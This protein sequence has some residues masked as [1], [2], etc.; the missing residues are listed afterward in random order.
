MKKTALLALLL[1]LTLVTASASALTLTGY[2][3]ESV[4]RYWEESRFFPRM[5]ALT[6]VSMEPKTVLEQ[7]EYDKLLAGMLRGSIPADV[8]FKAELTRD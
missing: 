1:M 4:T 6:G 2:E 3:T 5:E 7:D 8:L